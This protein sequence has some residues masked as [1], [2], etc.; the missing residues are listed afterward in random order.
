MTT[1]EQRARLKT[2][3]AEVSQL[4]RS[5]QNVELNCKHNWT[6]PVYAPIHHPAWTSPGDP[7][8]TMGVDWRGPSSFEA[9]TED[10]WTRYCLNCGKE[11]STNRSETK[12]VQ[13]K[14]VPQ[15]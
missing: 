3:E 5:I 10:K 1:Q 15:F 13:E 2:L 4:K 14:K 11:E 6:E 8:G 12:V 7:P 9:R